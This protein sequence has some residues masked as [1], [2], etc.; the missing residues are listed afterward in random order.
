MASDLEK[1]LIEHKLTFEEENMMVMD[2]DFSE[3]AEFFKG[4][5]ALE[6]YD[7]NFT[8]SKNVI[9]NMNSYIDELHKAGLDIGRGDSEF[10][11]KMPLPER[12]NGYRTL[13]IFRRR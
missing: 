1:R 3:I 10:G 11:Y 13:I 7:K 4:F 5:K 8:N 6:Y 9:N 12:N 2:P